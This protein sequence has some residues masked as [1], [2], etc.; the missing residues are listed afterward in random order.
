MNEQAMFLQL[1]QLFPKK[2]YAL[3]PQVG[4]A[5]GMFTRRHADAVALSLWPSRGI[6]LHGF[7]IKCDRRDWKRELENP[8]KAEE[9]AQF[10]HYWWVVVSDPSIVEE[11]ELPAG[12]GLIVYDATTD[13]LRKVKH[14]PFRD[15]APWPPMFFAALMRQAQEFAVPEA[16]LRENYDRGYTDGEASCQERITWETKQLR[17]LQERVRAFEKSSGISIMHDWRPAETIGRA[18]RTVLDGQME[19]HRQ[20]L[21]DIAQRVMQDLKVSPKTTE[22]GGRRSRR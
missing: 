14:A 12:W 8:E 13:E 15:A 22:N 18:V 9:I 4:N 10:C 19:F 2:E 1:R 5:T 3:L 17:E 11:G 20:A 7:E 21:V 6:H 16:E